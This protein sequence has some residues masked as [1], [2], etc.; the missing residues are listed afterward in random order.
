MCE[1]SPVTWNGAVYVCQAPPSRRYS[2]LKMPA[3]VPSVASS[4][5]V[6]FE[7]QPF[8]GGGESCAV[9]IGAAASAGSA[10]L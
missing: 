7:Y 3:P 4:V 2:V 10:M 9:V 1:P 5:T 6:G 8:T